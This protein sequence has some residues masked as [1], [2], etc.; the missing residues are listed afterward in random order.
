[1]D[2]YAQHGLETTPEFVRERQA[3]GLTWRLYRAEYDGIPVDLAFAE[4]QDRTLAV[5]LISDSHDHQ[6]LYKEVFL[7]VIDSVVPIK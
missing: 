2:H 3:N 5:L 1:M 7:P 6:I 4:T